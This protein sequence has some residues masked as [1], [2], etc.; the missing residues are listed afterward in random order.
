MGKIGFR[1]SE[2]S[3]KK[4]SEKM[5]GNKNPLGCKRSDETLQ[6]KCNQNKGCQIYN[7]GI[8]NKFIPVGAEIPPGFVKGMLLSEHEHKRRSDRYKKIDKERWEKYRDIKNE[9]EKK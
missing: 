2:E 4:T 8:I 5:K 7:N 1:H 6:K 3:K 9:E